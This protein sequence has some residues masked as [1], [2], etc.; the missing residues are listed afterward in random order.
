MV[1]EHFDHGAIN[2]DVQQQWLIGSKRKWP[3]PYVF[4]YVLAHAR[5]LPINK[6]ASL[7]AVVANEGLLCI[8]GRTAHPDA[9][10]RC[11]TWDQLRQDFQT[12]ALNFPE[13][14]ERRWQDG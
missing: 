4:L 13:M 10:F 9:Q 1:C 12:I 11:L 6:Q 2:E 5:S 7:Q 8:I 14:H 3:F